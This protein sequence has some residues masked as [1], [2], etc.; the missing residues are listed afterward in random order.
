LPARR[1]RL[2]AERHYRSLLAAPH[3]LP[4]YGWAL[5]ARLP[6][7]MAPLAIVLLVRGAGGSYGDAGLVT[8]CYS[9]ARA[10]AA[11]VFGR[12]VDRIGNVLALSPGAVVF[13]A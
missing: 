12:L 5:V 7:G 10:V 4:L 1:R 11:P 9:V 8:G 2:S 6:I 3:V 13:P